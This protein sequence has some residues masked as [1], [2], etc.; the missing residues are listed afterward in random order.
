MNSATLLHWCSLLLWTFIT[1]E[2]L[3]LNFVLRLQ[4]FQTYGYVIL[5]GIF[6][7]TKMKSLIWLSS[8]SFWVMMLTGSQTLT[9]VDL[10]WSLTYKSQRWINILSMKL[11][12]VTKFS[13]LSL[14]IPQITCDLCETVGSCS[15]YLFRSFC[16]QKVPILIPNNLWPLQ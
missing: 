16:D 10:S 4:G 11:C 6:I 14:L 13:N 5:V 3:L 2:A 7:P 15:Q 9:S 1:Y 8:L 12:K